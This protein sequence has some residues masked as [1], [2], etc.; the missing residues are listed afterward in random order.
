MRKNS[1]HAITSLISHR[2]RACPDPL[3]CP[4]R[5]HISRGA[6]GESRELLLLCTLTKR[7]VFVGAPF[8][9]S[10]SFSSCS[11]LLVLVLLSPARCCCCSSRAI[12]RVARRLRCGRRHQSLD[13]SDR[14][15]LFPHPSRRRVAALPPLLTSRPFP[16]RSGRRTATATIK[17]SRPCALPSLLR[18]SPSPSLSLSP[19]AL[20]MFTC[21]YPVHLHRVCSSRPYCLYL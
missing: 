13:Q 17:L 11:S 15:P 2:S 4:P 7:R 3:V 19:R 10:L 12:G 20:S 1:P 9:F 5:G 14:V 21:L 16:S 6:S 18:P 8:S